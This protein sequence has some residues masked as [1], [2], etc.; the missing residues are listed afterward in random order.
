LEPLAN[1]LPESDGALSLPRRYIRRANI[2]NPRRVISYGLFLST[3]PQEIFEADF[4]RQT[5]PGEWLAIAERH[6]QTD[7]T[8]NGRTRTELNRM[9]YTD[10]KITLGDNDLRKVGGTAELAG[11]AVRYPLLDRRLAE[12]SGKIPS[13]LKMK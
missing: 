8:G 6:H 11:V 2:P 1:C 7:D 3:P 13:S 5:P 10:V 9:L 12:F 4:L